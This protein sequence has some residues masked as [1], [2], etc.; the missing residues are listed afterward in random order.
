MQGSINHAAAI[1]TGQ[2]QQRLISPS[3]SP[4]L[5]N[6]LDGLS[7]GMTVKPMKS[8]YSVQLKTSPI[9]SSKNNHCFHCGD[10]TCP[11][12]RVHCNMCERYCHLM[13]LALTP[14]PLEGDK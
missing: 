1:V 4:P 5:M 11:Y 12:N 14:T 10:R 9:K 6:G 2:Q 13:C 3:A 7:P 8:S